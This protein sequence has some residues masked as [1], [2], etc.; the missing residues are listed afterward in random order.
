MKKYITILAVNVICYAAVAQTTPQYFATVEDLIADLKQS[1]P[2]N[3][4]LTNV[5][6][7]TNGA[8]VGVTLPPDRSTEHNLHL[9]SQIKSLKYLCIC[10]W[11]FTPTNAFSALAEYPNLTGLG[12]VCFGRRSHALTPELPALTN[13]QSLSLGQDSYRTNDAIY[14]AKMTNLMALEIAGRIPQTRAE[15]L[16]LTN[17]VNLRKLVI[18]GLDE[19]VDKVDTNIFSRL[20]KLTNLVVTSDILDPAMKDKVWNMPIVK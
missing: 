16:A 13:L 19:Y 7:D 12:L 9:L 3:F 17:L 1:P 4:Y 8:I 10:C 20:P 2:T 6:Y 18:C 11:S 14:L 5:F 15:L